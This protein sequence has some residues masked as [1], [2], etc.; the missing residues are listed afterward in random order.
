MDPTALQRTA[1]DV[2]AIACFRGGVRALSEHFAALADHSPAAII[3]A[4]SLPTGWR[5]AWK[6]VLLVLKKP[7]S[8]T[9]SVSS[10]QAGSSYATWTWG[11]VNLNG[12]YQSASARGT[13][14]QG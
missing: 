6:S 13:A 1:F 9:G 14:I 5:S 8:Q 2:V 4:P 7:T 3:T 12:T 10:P 11:Y